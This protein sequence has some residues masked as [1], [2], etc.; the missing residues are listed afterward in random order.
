MNQSLTNQSE[1]RLIVCVLFYTGGREAVQETCDQC[2]GR[3]R[4]TPHSGP[5]GRVH[6]SGGNR[7]RQ[8]PHRESL[9][10]DS[11]SVSHWCLSFADLLDGYT[12]N[13]HANLL[14]I[15]L[16]SISILLEDK[17]KE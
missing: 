14:V 15:G 11:V 16:N 8:R 2:R 6:H 12:V 7:N 3:G 9:L 10:I 4:G 1:S 5:A 17:E 13:L